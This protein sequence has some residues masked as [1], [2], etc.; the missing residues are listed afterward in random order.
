MECSQA[1]EHLSAYLDDGLDHPTRRQVEEHLALCQECRRELGDLRLLVHDL[2]SLPKI[3]APPDFLAQVHQRLEALSGW[4][5]VIRCLFFPWQIKV[6][7]ELAGVTAAVLLFVFT[8]QGLKTGKEMSYYPPP[9]GPSALGESSRESFALKA[10]PEVTPGIVGT[11][12]SRQDDALEK[13]RPLEL[14]LVIKFRPATE[15]SAL[16]RTRAPRKLPQTRAAAPSPRE[17]TN[18]WAPLAPPKMPIPGPDS[19]VAGKMAAPPPPRPASPPADQQVQEETGT[20]LEKEG[21][22]KPA[23]PLAAQPEFPRELTKPGARDPWLQVQDMVKSVHGTIISVQ[24]RPETHIPQSLTVDVPAPQLPLLL[25][26][27]RLVGE[28]PASPPNLIPADSRGMV[29]LHL[30]L[31]LPP[32]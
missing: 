18:G 7:L 3:A 23:E 17:T 2:H 1:H 14:A 19:T 9:A 11:T 15:E 29:R 4:R 22:A 32:Q 25:E 16:L 27:L 12:P 31:V 20:R 13:T 5:K 28:L 26:K 30:E 10:A 6:P 24:Y 8:Y 21:P